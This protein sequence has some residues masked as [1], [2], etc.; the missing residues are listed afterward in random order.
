MIHSS[1]YKPNIIPVLGTGSV[2]EIDRAQAIDPTVSL[3]RD[4]I[5][6]IG[7]DGAV[8]YLKKTPSVAYRLSQLEYGSIEFWQKIV[9]SEVLG[10]VGETGITLNDFKTPYFDILAYLTDDDDSFRGTIY[11]PALR[12]SGFSLSIGDPQGMIERSFDF[13]GESAQIWQGTNK[14]VIHDI[15][16]AGSGDDNEIDLTLKA[17]AEDPDNAGTYILRVVRVTAL[18]VSTVLDA[19]DYSYSNSTKILTIDSIITGD[20]IKYWLT[21]ATAPSTQ[22][23]LNDVDVAGLL[24]DS[25]SIYL[26][27]P[28]SGKPSASDYIYRLQ[29]VTLD[30]KFDREDLREIG[31]KNV[32]QRGIKNS[33]VTVSF[34]RILEQFTVE[35][36]LRG[37]V[38]GFGKIDVEK[39]SDDITLIVKIFSDNTKSALKYGFLA[40][41]LT[42]TE[43]R[44]G[45]NTNEYTKADTSLE[46]E[47]LII[48]A[49]ATVLGI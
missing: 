45:A 42:A 38:A 11:Y 9:N 24:G 25:A 36:V 41:G 39:F 5:E 49:D 30:V 1:Y 37:E 47:N 40:T 33:T 21:S 46:G 10:E 4:K 44:G 14:Y 8:G 28:S 15:H 23:A 48:S 29:S 6:E 27:I 13:V 20:I 32:V 34:N 43:M 16:T 17:P 7:R 35:E 31:N 18:G 26:Y 19:T 22:F 2:A 3:N 12:T